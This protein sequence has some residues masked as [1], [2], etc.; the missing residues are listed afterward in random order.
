MREAR[1]GV[2]QRGGCIALERPAVFAQLALRLQVGELHPE[3]LHLL[4]ADAGGLQAAIRL[5]PRAPLRIRPL[6]HSLRGLSA[7]HDGDARRLHR[8]G[9]GRLLEVRELLHRGAEPRVGTDTDRQ[10]PDGAVCGRSAVGAERRDPRRLAS[11]SL[12]MRRRRIVPPRAIE[13]AVLT[14]ISF[15]RCHLRERRQPERGAVI[16][17]HCPAKAYEGD[18]ML[19]PLERDGDLGA[20]FQFR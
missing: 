9:V 16:G 20:G 4:A 10:E 17:R 8:I 13:V 19:G 18:E 6:R 15:R 7:I 1:P 14:L 3:D 12:Q 2:L 5:G 11:G